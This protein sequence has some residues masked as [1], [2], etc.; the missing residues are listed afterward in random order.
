MIEYT[1]ELVSPRIAE[2]LLVTTPHGSADWTVE[3]SGKGATTGDLRIVTEGI[4]FTVIEIS[5]KQLEEL[6]DVFNRAAGMI[7]LCS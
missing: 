2:S 4:I 3:Q 1:P 5:P 7:R 6:A